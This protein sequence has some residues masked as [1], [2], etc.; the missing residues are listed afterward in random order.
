MT[1]KEN[2]ESLDIAVL[3]PFHSLLIRQLCLTF[4]SEHRALSKFVSCLHHYYTN[5]EDQSFI[6]LT[7]SHQK[8]LLFIKFNIPGSENEILFLQS[9]PLATQGIEIKLKMDSRF[10]GND[11]RAAPHLQVSTR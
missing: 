6:I 4:Q 8:Y 3:E 2:I 1:M 9:L 7:L 11:N 10:H 5:G